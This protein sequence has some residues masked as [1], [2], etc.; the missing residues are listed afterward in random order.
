MPATP[1]DVRK[2]NRSDSSVEPAAKRIKL[3]HSGDD[4]DGS[5]GE[6]S[7]EEMDG[8]CCP[9]TRLVDVLAFAADPED[10]E[11]MV[12]VLRDL[13]APPRVSK[14]AR[15]A[16]Y[17]ELFGANHLAS[18]SALRCVTQPMLQEIGIP[19]GHAHAIM[20]ALFKTTSAPSTWGAQPSISTD[21]ALLRMTGHKL[22]RVRAEYEARVA[23]HEEVPDSRAPPAIRR[24][25]RAFK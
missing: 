10:E 23:L 24:S 12:E 15:A 7:D 25:S 3:V 1:K 13:F 6:E 17:A 18:A 11:L 19:F 9:E 21:S 22:D 14:Q 16:D 8:S 5:A 2:T 4:A 20:L